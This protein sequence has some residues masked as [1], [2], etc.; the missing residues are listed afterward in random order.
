MR[1]LSS[2]LSDGSKW[3]FGCLSTLLRRNPLSLIVS[4]MRYAKDDRARKIVDAHEVGARLRSRH[5]SCPSCGARVHYKRSIGLCPDPIFAHNPHEGSPDCE[6]YYPWQGIY[7]GTPSSGPRPKPAEEDSPDEFGFGL[8]D[9]DAWTLYLRVPAVTPVELGSVPLR[10]LTSAFVEVDSGGGRN[11]L[12]L[13]DLRPGV[14]FARLSVSPSTVGYKVVTTGSWPQ[15]IRPGRWQAVGRGLSARGTLFRRRH[16]EWV[17]LREG[18]PVQL[19]EELRVVADQ[20]SAPPAECRPVAANTVSFRGQS[21]RMW[22]LTL[23]TAETGQFARWLESLGLEAVEPVWEVHVA[24]VPE[25]ISDDGQTL[26]YSTRRPLIAHL[27][28]PQP[29]AKA[30][31]SLET[32][33]NRFSESVATPPKSDRAFLV[34][35]VAWPGTNELTVAYDDRTTVSFETREAEKLSKIKNALARVPRLEITIGETIVRGWDERAEIVL[36]LRTEEVPGVAVRPAV[37]DVRVNLSWSGP[38]GEGS[39]EGISPEILVSRLKAFLER[40]EGAEVRI[41]GGGLGSITLG[42]RAVTRRQAALSPVVARKLRWV[43]A[44]INENV[45]DGAP[46]SAWQYRRLSALD[47]KLAVSA[48]KKDSRWTPLVVRALREVEPQ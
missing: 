21:W 29:G 36:P 43:G 44:G 7:V 38:D 42:F 24:S 32:G 39:D 11:R 26:V 48:R 15:G 23:P 8:D 17:R 18:S 30:D 20:K 5:Y 41:D 12:P 47:R 3:A 40:R 13:I 6:S 22:R 31:S 35:S 19:G 25:G 4:E 37:D 9:A 16:G 10:A 46:V 45:G 28:S 1:H 27:R 2:L 33:T 34:F 14:S